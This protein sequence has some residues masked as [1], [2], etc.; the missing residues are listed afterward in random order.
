ER[1]EV[2]RHEEGDD[3][4]RERRAR[5]GHGLVRAGNEREGGA[6]GSDLSAVGERRTLW[7]VLAPIYI[8]RADA[9]DGRPGR[10]VEREVVPQ[11]AGRSH[12]HDGLHGW[13]LVW[14][15]T[16][17]PVL[18][19]RWQWAVEVGEQC[20]ITRAQRCGQQGTQ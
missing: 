11:V 17:A 3:R 15:V 5:I 20:V 2:D 13:P 9:D 16:V 10:R 7:I 18:A 14:H 19:G 4:R 1:D 8:E 6:R 12:V